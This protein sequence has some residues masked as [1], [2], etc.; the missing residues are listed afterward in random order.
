[1][2][3][4]FTH[5]H[6]HTHTQDSDG[7]NCTNWSN[8]NETVTTP[9]PES[10]ACH[11]PQV[12]PG[13]WK[14]YLVLLSSFFLLNLLTFLYFTSPLIFSLPPPPFLSPFLPSSLLPLSLPLSLPLFLPLFLLYFCLIPFL[15]QLFSFPLLL[16]VSTLPTSSVP[17]LTLLSLLFPLFSLL[18]RF[19]PYHCSLSVPCSLTPFPTALLLF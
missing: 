16:S 1:M 15:C 2:S 17:H 13:E 14:S 3:C 10:T 5:T 6:T 7:C 18:K 9:N 4:L 19:N 8:W 11:Y 12:F